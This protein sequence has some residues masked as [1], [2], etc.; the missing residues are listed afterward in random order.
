[1]ENRLYG[2]LSGIAKKSNVSILSINGTSDHI[3]LLI[4]LNASKPVSVL[5]KELKSYSTGWMKKQGIFNFAWQEGY[6][7]FSCSITHLKQLINYIENQ[8]EHHKVKSFE[9]EIEKLNSLWKTQ[10]KV[11]KL[12]DSNDSVLE[13]DSI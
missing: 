9:D 10:W 7:A 8:K 11:D 1:M 6:G 12:E 4:K 5:I 2:Y 13:D 3:H